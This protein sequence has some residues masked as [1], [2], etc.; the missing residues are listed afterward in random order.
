MCHLLYLS[1]NYLWGKDSLPTRDSRPDP[2]V[3]FI[4]E[5][6]LYLN[7][8]GK[9]SLPTRDSRPDPNV[10]FIQEVPLYLSVN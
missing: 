7:L 2:N 9:D 5:V 6:P 8:W 3:S 1:V 4:Q 10:S